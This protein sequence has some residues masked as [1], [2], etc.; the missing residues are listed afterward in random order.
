M[1]KCIARMNALFNK[2]PA[3]LYG[4]DGIDQSGNAQSAR[5]DGQYH[6]GSYDCPDIDTNNTFDAVTLAGTSVTT[7]AYTFCTVKTCVEPVRPSDDGPQFPVVQTIDNL[8]PRAAIIP[9][10]PPNGSTF[11]TEEEPGIFYCPGNLVTNNLTVYGILLVEGNVELDGNANS[12]K[13]LALVKG[14]S[15]VK[16]GG[17]VA[18]YG[19]WLGQGMVTLDGGVEFYYDCRVFQNLLDSY[20]RYNMLAW[21]QE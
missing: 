7:T 20:E 14:T 1:V 3:P 19:A 10:N 11:G 12:I 4:A 15:L 8:K 6:T 17:N 18:S 21:M 9:T 5:A 13:G 2:I 16:G